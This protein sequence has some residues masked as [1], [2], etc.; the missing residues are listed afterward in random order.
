MDNV[1]QR[2]QN[3]EAIVVMVGLVMTGEGLSVSVSEVLSESVEGEFTDAE[4]FVVPPMI[5]AAAM[6]MM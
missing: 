1:L 4:E 2:L 5:L 6:S 3:G